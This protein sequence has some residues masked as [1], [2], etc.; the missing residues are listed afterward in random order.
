MIFFFFFFTEKE[1]PSPRLYEDFDFWK[2]IVNAKYGKPLTLPVTLKMKMKRSATLRL[3]LPRP[4]CS[5]VC[6]SRLIKRFMSKAY[7]EIYEKHIKTN[8]NRHILVTG[9]PGTGKTLFSLYV[10]YILLRELPEDGIVYGMLSEKVFYIRRG[11]AQLLSPRV[12]ITF[13]ITYTTV[14]R[15]Q[16]YQ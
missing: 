14:D 13:L 16:P 3:R 7:T 6:H 2:N 10:A 1:E 11:E 5:F 12:C 15:I 9:N 8:R 4:Y